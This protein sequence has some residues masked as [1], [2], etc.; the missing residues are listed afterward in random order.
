MIHKW[1]PSGCVAT[2]C[3]D[4][5]TQVNTEHTIVRKNDILVLIRQGR[6][7]GALHICCCLTLSHS[8]TFLVQELRYIEANHDCIKGNA[9]MAAWWCLLQYLSLVAAKKKDLHTVGIRDSSS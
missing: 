3:P 9:R 2:C 6:L 1:L 7:F 4:I 5:A 8:L